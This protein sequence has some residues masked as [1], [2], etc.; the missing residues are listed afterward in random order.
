MTES[1]DP[2]D[3][4]SIYNW[5]RLSANLTTSGQ[6]SEAALAALRDMGVRTIINLG[7]HSHPHALPDEAASVAAL[8]M[9]YIHIPVDFANPTEED[10]SMFCN[11]LSEVSDTPLHVH[12]IANYRVSA[13]FARYRRDHL[14]WS[15][16]DARA[17]MDAIWQPEGVWA[18]FVPK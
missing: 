15:D 12:C 13:F 4:T 17:D 10:Y 8:G 14:G 5:Q 1:D 18:D 7:L 3:V 2:Q 9:R 16:A 6:P 11:V